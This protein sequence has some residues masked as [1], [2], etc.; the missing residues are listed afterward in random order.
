[1]AEGRAAART[2]FGTGK[3]ERALTVHV[4]PRDL[5]GPAGER[6][7][8]GLCFVGEVGVL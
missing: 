4:R 3:S 2:A 8:G 1:M 5:V 7:I 6:N